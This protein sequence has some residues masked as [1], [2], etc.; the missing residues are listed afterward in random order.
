RNLDPAI[1]EL[2]NVHLYDIDDLE[3]IVEDNLEQRRR[4][5]EK[6][7]AMIEREISEHEYWFKTLHVGPVI[8]ALQDRSRSLHDE[9]LQS[10]YNKR[11]QLND[12]QRKVIH[13][14]TRSIVN[15]MLEDPITRL[16]ELAA[17]E[18]GEEAVEIFT[19]IFA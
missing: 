2:T 13:K 11:P 6:I 3:G 15:Q 17:E 16:K 5:A 8:R 14:L 19:R 7:E 12:R 18:E 4:E 1:A 9:T 10:L